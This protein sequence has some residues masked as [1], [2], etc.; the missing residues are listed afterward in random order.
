MALDHD[1]ELYARQS[2]GNYFVHGLDAVDHFTSVDLF[3]SAPN[4]R[5]DGYRIARG[6]QHNGHGNSRERHKLLGKLHERIVE[7]RFDGRF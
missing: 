1:M 4:K 3:D 7:L 2:A 6:T 5:H